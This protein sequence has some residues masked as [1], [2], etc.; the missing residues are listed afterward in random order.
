EPEWDELVKKHRGTGLQQ[1]FQKLAED[2]VEAAFKPQKVERIPEIHDGEVRELLEDARER[3]EVEEVAGRLDIEELLDRELSQL[4]GGEL[5]RV[6]IA[7]TLLK[8]RDIYMF[9]EPSSFLDVKQ[10]LNVAREIR[11]L[12]QE[13]AVMV[14][15]H[16]LAT[17]DLVADSIHIFYGEPGS[18]GMVSNALSS[19]NGI[20]QYLEGMLPSHNLRFRDSS[21]E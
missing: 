1:H 10:R 2:K 14:V 21:I 5:Q 11:K 13:S 6:A 15:E 9:D 18:Y 12:S 8:E 16:D 17:L 7:S 19:K 20:N 4:S 3:L